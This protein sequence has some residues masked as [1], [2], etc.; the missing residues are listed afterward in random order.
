MVGPKV[1]G[2]SSSRRA[3]LRNLG[4]FSGCNTLLL[5]RIVTPVDVGIPLNLLILDVPAMTLN[6]VA[7]LSVLNEIQCVYTL[8]CN[9]HILVFK[10][11]HREDEL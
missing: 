2:C 11:H 5:T 10:I 4:L 8:I 1:R 3:R 6:P 9:C 7:G